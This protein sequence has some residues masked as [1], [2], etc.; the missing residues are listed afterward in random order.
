MSSKFGIC[1]NHSNGFI[2]N[3]L[4][5]QFVLLVVSMVEGRPHGHY[6]CQVQC[7]HCLWTQ[8]IH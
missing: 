4:Y 6:Q 1:Q 3:R 8:W 5:R 2:H 7:L